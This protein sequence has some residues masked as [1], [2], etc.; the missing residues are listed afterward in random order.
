ML[1]RYQ[2]V[3]EFSTQLD[4]GIAFPTPPRKILSTLFPDLTLFLSPLSGP[5]DSESPTVAIYRAGY[6]TKLCRILISVQR[7]DCYIFGSSADTNGAQQELL[8]QL[9]A[10]LIDNYGLA[11]GGFRFA[12]IVG[13]PTELEVNEIGLYKLLF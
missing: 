4:S 13:L 10:Y 5:S 8:T 2:K 1:S 7:H 3:V 11:S 6:P 9:H 12:E